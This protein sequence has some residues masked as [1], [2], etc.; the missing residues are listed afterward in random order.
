MFNLFKKKS[1]LEKLEKEY[2]ALLSESHRLST[3]DRQASDKKLA[4]A[5]E[6]AKK[7]E[8]LR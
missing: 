2:K 6:I 4:E 7:I 8:A 1:P 3:I 5:E